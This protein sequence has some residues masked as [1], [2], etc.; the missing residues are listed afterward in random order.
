[1]AKS[2]IQ[3]AKESEQIAQ[4]KTST[5]PTSPTA[6]AQQSEQIANTP[7]VWPEPELF[8]EPQVQQPPVQEIPETPIETPE[9]PKIEPIK[10]IKT[11][12]PVQQVQEVKNQALI[13]E[14]DEIAVNEQKKQQVASEF[15]KKLAS[16]AS[17]KELADFARNNEQYQDSFR[18]TLRTQFKTQENTKFFAKYNGM[19]NESMYSAVKNGTVKVWSERYNMLS[20]AQRQSFEQFKAVKDAPQGIPT[21]K[22]EVF[23]PN[24]PENSVDFSN[25]EQFANK[26]FS[27]DLRQELENMRND[28]RVVNLSQELNAKAS[29]LEIFDIKGIKENDKLEK[30][31]WDASFTPAYIRAKLRDNTANRAIE[32]MSMVSEYNRVQGDLTSIKDDIESDIKM[33]EYE[34]QQAKDKYSFLFSVYES[35]RSEDMAAKSEQENREFEVAMIEFEEQNKQLATQRQQD[36]Q[37]QMKQIDQEFQLKNQKPSYEIG[38]DGKMYAILDWQATVVKWDMWEVLFWEENNNHIKS[39]YDNKDGTFTEVTTFKD[40][41]PVAIAT[42]DAQGNKV[43]GTPDSVQSIIEQCR[44]TGQCGAWVN[45][46]LQNLWLGRLMWNSYESKA[47]NINSDTPVLWGVAIWNPQQGQGEFKEYGHTGI[48]T[49]VNTENGTVTITDWNWNGDEKQQTREVKM[50][51]ITYNGG[52]MNFTEQDAVTYSD[53]DVPMYKKYLQGKIT[54]S[55]QKTIE[56]FEQF[57]QEAL[58]YQN[59][60]TEQGTP[61]IEKLIDLASD[62]R[63]NSPWRKSRIAAW[64]SL[65]QTVS[66]NLAD[67][68][69]NFDAFISNNALDQLVQLKSD[70]ATFGALS[71]KELQFIQS[72]ATNLRANL[73]DDAFKWELNRIIETL[74][75]G[76]SEDRVQEITEEPIQES[77]TWQTW[78][79]L[80][81]FEST[82]DVT[83]YDTILNR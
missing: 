10:A 51:E 54:A 49:W 63:D 39:I 42:Y 41:R 1:M 83:E 40:D 7:K 3:I 60:L 68:Q 21:T 56:D 71:D 38:R 26:M 59:N 5:A 81:D 27:S 37:L 44:V 73:S 58:D 4:Q 65:W 77:Q 52:F 79:L 24:T 17:T 14:S 18:D 25:I 31:M 82:F 43:L 57:K 23:N 46:Y 70:G 13:N 8:A 15:E 35:R 30:E 50:S 55:D 80:T 11:E 19:S 29:E 28:D 75:R 16:G 34:D 47:K 6:I 22:E 78:T 20:E 36:F 72:S 32:R 12:E 62:L 9:A 61:Q 2:A 33:L 76:L 69:A 45:D 64:T 48:V 66:S 74:Q 53:A 67:Y